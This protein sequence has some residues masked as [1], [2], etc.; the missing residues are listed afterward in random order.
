MVLGF[1]RN[2]ASSSNVQIDALIA[3]RLRPSS[4]PFVSGDTFR[5]QADVICDETGAFGSWRQSGVA[6]CAT[7]Y[8]GLLLEQATQDRYAELAATMTVLVHNGDVNPSV[9]EYEALRSC[10]ARVMSVNLTPELDELGVLPLPIGIENLHWRK[11]GLLEY[12]DGPAERERQRAAQLRPVAVLA[13]F[14]TQTNPAERE[15]LKDRAIASGARW[16]EPSPDCASYFASVRDAMFVLSPP[17]NGL[18]CHRTWEAIYLGA[19]PVV[20]R[21]TLPASLVDP[22]PIM[23][24]DDWD[25]ILELDD[26]GKRVVAASLA[27]RP[28]E[29]A[30]MPYWCR[31][32]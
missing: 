14:R 16:I 22:L 32:L 11:N 5:S 29:S 27:Q 18:D 28:V 23:Q 21:G 9:S 19:V 3:A 31:R 15:S 12:F 6:F 26:H 17:G 30:Y 10:F 1:G 24:V 8:A 25:E 13:S 2:R 7:R 20:R 4:F